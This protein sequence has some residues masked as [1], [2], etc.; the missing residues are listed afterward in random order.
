MTNLLSRTL[1]IALLL[2]GAF[3]SLPGRSETIETQLTDAA[4]EASRAVTGLPQAPHQAPANDHRELAPPDPQVVDG[5]PEPLA[6][7]PERRLTVILDWYPTPYHAALIVARERGLF[8]RAGLD[9]ALTVPADPTVP[10]KLVAAQ[11][12][13]LAVTSQPRLHLLVAQGLPLVRVGTL[14][15][16]PLATLMVRKDSGIDTL[17]Q[18][19]GKTVGYIHEAPARLMLAGLLD[20]LAFSLD[21][22]SLQHID[23][24]LTRSLA[25]GE[26]DA[27]I[28]TLR[29]VARHQ[30][31]QEGVSV[32]EHRVEE[33]DIP[34][35]DELILVANRNALK[36]HRRDI[37]RFLDA[38]EIATLWMINHP[39][40]AW[41][42]VR[43]TEPSLNTEANAH[44][45][46]DTLRY[47]ALRPA[48]AQ[49][50]RYS[51]FER[52][53]RQQALIDILTPV[54]R[55]I[56]DLSTP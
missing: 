13:E 31:A 46:P 45:W 3:T 17:S 38:L 29:H 8:T 47:L 56:T 20:G 11:R 44:A 42:L 5:E 51:R 15:P 49:A 55:L 26:V 14:V 43:S 23:F 52:Y 37:A 10:A 16:A 24:A 28:G 7:P 19:K 12:A 22:I 21:D 50:Q 6:P 18:L 53:M 30:L 2:F 34:A 40:Q 25:E 33:G 36:R 1:P 9:V 39:Q 4:I 27:V 32:S 48:S 41:E 35:Y 54:E